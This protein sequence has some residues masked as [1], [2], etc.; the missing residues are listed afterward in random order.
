MEVAGPSQPSSPSVPRAAQAG[1]SAAAQAAQYQLQQWEP[2]QE[3]SPLGP[4]AEL[5]LSPRRP[6]FELPVTPPFI[7]LGPRAELPFSHLQLSPAALQPWLQPWQ[8]YLPAPGPESPSHFFL[9]SPNIQSIPIINTLQTIPA[10]ELDCRI[11]LEPLMTTPQE[12]VYWLIP[13]KHAFHSKCILE[14]NKYSN[15]CP[16]CRVKIDSYSTTRPE[17]NYT[18]GGTKY[19]INHKYKKNHKYK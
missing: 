10:K 19:K 5:S 1:L 12:T 14:S 16:Q 9:D 18:Y 13:C 8:Q 2:L 3:W 11:C 15:N 17:G 6:L 7:P 4:R